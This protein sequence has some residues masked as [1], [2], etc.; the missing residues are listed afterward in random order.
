MLFFNLCVNSRFRVKDDVV[1][2]YGEFHEKCYTFP[3]YIQYHG[4]VQLVRPA[5][6][7]RRTLNISCACGL[8]P[9]Q[10]LL[11]LN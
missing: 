5:S 6:Q 11:V 4:G 1:C 9:T 7:S 2:G 3:N 8:Q 10:V